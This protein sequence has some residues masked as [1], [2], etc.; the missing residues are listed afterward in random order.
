LHRNHG[1]PQKRGKRSV[2][3][4]DIKG[5]I[6]ATFFS[7]LKQIDGRVLDPPAEYA[8]FPG[9]YAVCFTDPDGIKIQVVHWPEPWPSLERRPSGLLRRLLNAA[10]ERG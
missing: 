8:Y 3:H 7:P 6:I 10:V 9:Y 2:Y 4:V 5:G 1:A